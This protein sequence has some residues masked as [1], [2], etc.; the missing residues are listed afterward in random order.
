ME[1]I[2]FCGIQGAGKS[3]FYKKYFFNT[4]VRISLDL[5]KTRN[6]EWQFLQTCIRTRQRFVVD[7]TCPAAEDRKKYIDIARAAG[8]SVI[9]YFFDTPLS[10]ALKRNEKRSG[11]A[12]VPVAGIKGTYNKLQPPDLSE[13]FDELVILK[14]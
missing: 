2:I 11:K 3:T 14:T 6:R 1:A 13:G 4:H 9:C 5:L 7:N 8:F 12:R 10:E